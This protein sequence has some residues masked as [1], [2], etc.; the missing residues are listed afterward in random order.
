MKRHNK[1]I[2]LFFLIISSLIITSFVSAYDCVVPTNDKI[3]NDVLFCEGSYYIPDGLNLDDGVTVDCN[4]AEIVGDG[5][6]QGVFLDDQKDITIKNCL[7]K[8]F[9][10]GIVILDSKNIFITSNTL[11]NNTNGVR[12]YT[13]K[14]IKVN[15]NIVRDNIN[16]GLHFVSCVDCEHSAN[17]LDGNKN[18][19]IL[20]YA[21]YTGDNTCPNNCNATVDYDCPAECGDDL[22]STAGDCDCG[23]GDVPIDQ[24]IVDVSIDDLNDELDDK[25]DDK[26]DD[27]ATDSYIDADDNDGYQNKSDNIVASYDALEEVVLNFNVDG[28][29]SQVTGSSD[30]V[31]L[32]G[33]NIVYP[34]VS[35]IDIY[36]PLDVL[37]KFGSNDNF[38]SYFDKKLELKKKKIVYQ[39]KTIIELKIKPK[40][41][42]PLLEIY[43]YF[44]KDVLQNASEI[45]VNVKFKPVK[46]KQSVKVKLTRLKKDKEVIVMFTIDKPLFDGHSYTILNRI[47][48]SR[49][50]FINLFL[51]LI[52]LIFLYY[53]IQLKQVLKKHTMYLHRHLTEHYIIL[54]KDKLLGLF[55]LVPFLVIVLF[56]L[57]NTLKLF[58]TL[59]LLR[60]VVLI[61][62]IFYLLMLF[63]YMNDL[64]GFKRRYGI[65]SKKKW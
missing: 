22:C 14:N 54:T 7:F 57:E 5:S 19:M 40:K 25:K 26:P 1:P 42:I 49:D 60:I 41:Y 23:E 58:L 20:E 59:W 34:I 51:L 4:N 30:M 53:H 6:T 35:D 24:Q 17:V 2:I 18:A 27:T 56:L 15:K 43:E 64:S 63:A 3:L 52:L 21:C 36:V 62:F 31:D 10:E 12:V 55:N 9:F 11:V 45:D 65:K 48:H 37:D 28:D 16:V 39:D 50:L 13:S 38:Q 44:P 33:S 46:D 32:S 8:N 47:Y 29:A 61:V